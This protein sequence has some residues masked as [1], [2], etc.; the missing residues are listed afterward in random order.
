MRYFTRLLV[1][2]CLSASMVYA[3][4]QTKFSPAQ[5]E[6]LNVRNALRETAL[7]RDM[8]AWSRY[9]AD[10]C[11]FST[12]D[13]TL[14]TKAHFIEHVG[15]LPPEYDRTVNPRDY[16]IHV[17]GN[18]AVINFRLTGHEQFTDADIISEMRQTETYV[19]QNGSWL[20]V[21][22]QWGKLPVNF[23][24][25]VAVD[26]SVYKDYVGQYEWRP[27]VDVETV[28]VKDGKLWSQIGKDEDEYMPLGSDTFFVKSDLGSATFSRD[29]Q[30]HVIGYTYHRD[31][32]QE[33]HV[34]KIK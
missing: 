23:R 10:D 6:V 32:G 27:L 9:V 30:G 33:I 19:K 1:A 8:A 13:G 21:A 31:D 12:D 26:T 5:Q 3:A 34:K 18:T 24:K 7:R 25:P 29:A 16:V 4:D 15:K 11:I 14:V 28:F 2:L 20:L 22:R 17:Y